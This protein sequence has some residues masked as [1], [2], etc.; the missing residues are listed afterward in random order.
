MKG[1]NTLIKPIWFTHIEKVPQG[2]FYHSCEL[3]GQFMVRV[4]GITLTL[5]TLS[6]C[7]DSSP[8][9]IHRTSG[10]GI[11]YLSELYDSRHLEIFR[12]LFSVF[13][14]KGKTP[15]YSFSLCVYSSSTLTTI[16][17]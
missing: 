15:V 16:L 6:I 13:D 9:N 12:R 10:A 3:S 11:D 7:W 5:L 17:H 14:L 1:H 4:C 2:Y 8:R